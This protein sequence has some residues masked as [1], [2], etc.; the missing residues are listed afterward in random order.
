[1][2]FR[3]FPNFFVRLQSEDEPQRSEEEQLTNAIDRLDRA[4]DRTEDDDRG[5]S[6][7]GAHRVVSSPRVKTN[8]LTP[9]AMTSVA[10]G[11]R[12]SLDDRFTHSEVL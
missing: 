7:V 2:N 12:S 11:A 10:L 4:F 3:V 1:M 8:T 9:R 6:L 5:L